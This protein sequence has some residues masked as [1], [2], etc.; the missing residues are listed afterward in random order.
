MKSYDVLG[1][2]KAALFRKY[3]DQS[4]MCVCSSIHPSLVFKLRAAT[5]F[6]LITHLGIPTSE[7]GTTLSDSITGEPRKTMTVNERHIS[8]QANS[9]CSADRCTAFSFHTLFIKVIVCT[10]EVRIWQM[11]GWKRWINHLDI[12]WRFKF[13]PGVKMSFGKSS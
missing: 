4:C 1:D 8:A 5:L 11:G 9:T 2:T 12:E 10:Y 7:T 13:S 6:C 3:W